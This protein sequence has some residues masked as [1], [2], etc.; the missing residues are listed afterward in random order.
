MFKFKKCY[1]LIVILLV[2]GIVFL[3]GLDNITRAEENSNLTITNVVISNITSTEATV[4]WNTAEELRG[5]VW[6]RKYGDGDNWLFKVSDEPTKVHSAILLNLVPSTNY[7][8]YITALDAQTNLVDKTDIKIFKTINDA[9]FCTD[10]DNGKD[11]YAKGT[12]IDKNGDILEDKCIYDLNESQLGTDMNK[13]D[14]NQLLEYSC[15]SDGRHA[16]TLYFCPNGCQDGACVSNNVACDLEYDP[17]CGI[18]GKT[19]SNKCVA[20]SQNDVSIDYYG[21]CEGIK[22]KEKFYRYAKWICYDNYEEI[23]ED[24]TSCKSE[25]TWEEYANESCEEHCLGDKCGVN[26]FSVNKECKSD[27][28]IIEIKNKASYLK[29]NK[30]SEILTGLKELRNIV[31]EQQTQIKYLSNL[32]KDVEALSETVENALNNFITYG[33][34]DNTKKLG[35]GERAAVIYSYKSAFNKLPETEDELADV[36]K[37]ANGR[38]PSLTSDDAEKQAKEQFQKIYKRIADNNN[39]DKA[40]VTVM[41]YGLRQKAENRNLDSEKQGIKTF[42]NIYGYN[43]N[44]TEDWNIMQAITYSGAT[45]GVDTDGDLLTDE[46][47]KGLG[48]D[49]NNKDSD[50][51]GYLDGIEVANGHDPLKK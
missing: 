36:I 21:E 15:L 8:Y 39:S 40:A 13:D 18:D 46:R 7:E 4:T 16:Y 12:V 37:I 22:E 35:E 45:R 1:T 2:C 10:S 26:Y 5:Y 49:P 48:T 25:E 33:V 51:D 31:K 11:Y 47:E 50:G 32:K 44:T 38:W 42:R 24:N 43:P 27:Y 23:S 3:V 6:Y 30:L 34:D 9:E 17:V 29:E 28:N 41:A 14:K 19:Y 20:V